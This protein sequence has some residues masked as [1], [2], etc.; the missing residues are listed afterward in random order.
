MSKRIELLIIDPQV[1]FCDPS[2]G[3][4][5]VP[6]AERDMTRLAQMIRRLKEKIDD[7]HVTLD[8]HH[9][10]HIAHPIFWKD[11]RGAHPPV[12]TSISRADVEEGVWTPSAPGMYRRAL[13]YVRKLEEN[14]R[15]GLTIWPPHCLI[16]SPGH[17]VY[18]ELFQ[19]LAEWEAR[20]AFVDY[21]TKGSNLLTEHY[22]A[23][24]AD[25]PDPADA[26]TQINTRL[27]QT[28]ENADLIIIAG[29]ARTHCL[30]NT[31]RDIANNFGDDSFVSKLVLLTDASS[32]IPGFEAHAQNFMSEMTGRGMG[33]STTT[34][35]LA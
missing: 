23:V 34:E 14:G 29:E 17:A 18:P 10:I 7:I 28:L 19:A 33:L 13:D 15:Y 2:R 24:Q 9:S 3:A 32:D 35:F 27:I 4:L 31:V 5:Y 30:A 20:F 26:S 12:F 8:S 11:S 22:S 1:D 21:V 16:G 6:G 25:V